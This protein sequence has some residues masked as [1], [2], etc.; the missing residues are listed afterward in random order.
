VSLRS[1]AVQPRNTSHVQATAAIPSYSA[2]QLNGSYVGPFVTGSTAPSCSTTAD[3]AQCEGQAYSN[4]ASYSLHY[5]SLPQ[6]LSWV[7]QDGYNNLDA[8]ILKNINFTERVYLQLR[9]ET[10][11]TL[12]HPVFSAPN[13]SSATASNFGEIT[14][15]ASN[16]QP[17][18]VQ[19]G[20]RIVF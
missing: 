10:F 9:F 18:Q 15:V 11:N 20:A 6:T 14:A 8:S 2:G 16:S 19:L 7:R 12:N 13:V 17:R 4:D 1:I 3:S 5:R